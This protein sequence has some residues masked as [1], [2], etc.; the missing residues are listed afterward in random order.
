MVGLWPAAFEGTELDPAV[1]RGR[2]EKLVA[3][4]E[5]L[6]ADQSPA[7]PAAAL[8]PAERLAQQWRDRLASNTIAGGAGGKGDDARWRAAEQDV[9]SAQQ[10]W[11]RLGPVPPAVATEMTARFD[12][13]C[14]RF[15][16]QRKRAS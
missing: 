4:V 14:R 13:A 15:F 10:Q 16:E 7:R 11:Q 12:A 5:K 2:M 6:L 8:S 9:R 3:R 1:T